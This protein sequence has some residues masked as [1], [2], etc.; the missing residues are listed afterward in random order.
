MSKKTG[1]KHHQRTLIGITLA[2]LL[3]VS[4][5]C[6]SSEEGTS[7]LVK[8]PNVLF[9][10]LDDMNDWV[11]TLGGHEQALTPAL[12]KFSESGVVLRSKLD[13]VWPNCLLQAMEKEVSREDTPGCTDDP[14]LLIKGTDID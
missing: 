1:K 6:N 14:Q 12:D 5:P 11:G 10:S 3:M 9:I 4:V 13:M 7:A 8:H 2:I